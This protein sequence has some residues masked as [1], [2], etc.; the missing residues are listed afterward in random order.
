MVQNY[1]S[2]SAR[3][4]QFDSTP[5]LDGKS[6]VLSYL[7]IFFS[8]LIFWELLNPLMQSKWDSITACAPN[9]APRG[10]VNI[11]DV[12]AAGCQEK[13]RCAVWAPAEGR[14]PSSS[15]A[16][17]AES[18][19][20]LTVPSLGAQGA[21]ENISFIHAWKLEYFF[22]DSNFTSSGE[23]AFPPI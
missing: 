11:G 5:V 1:W 15:Q 17:K 3:S 18:R 13:P 21:Q 12:M 23:V 19:Y 10:R 16:E 8:D 4:N 2:L 7:A 20:R 22:P 14:L 9:P 6:W